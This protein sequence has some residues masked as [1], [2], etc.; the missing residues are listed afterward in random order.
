MNH[1]SGIDRYLKLYNFIEGDFILDINKIFFDVKGFEHPQDRVVAYPRYFP[2]K[3]SNSD[4]MYYNIKYKKVYNLEDRIDILKHELQSYYVYDRVFDDYMCEVPVKN[5][6]KHFKPAIATEE[7]CSNTNLSL[8]KKVALSLI[9]LISDV[10]GV[11]IKYI[12]ISGSIMIDLYRNDS[13][14]DLI[15][16]GESNSYKVIR[17]LNK[18]FNEGLLRKYEG[19]EISKLYKFRKAYE[20]TNLKTFY[21]HEKRKLYQGIYNNRE[22][23]IRFVKEPSHKYGDYTYKNLGRIEAIAVITDDKESI[24]TPSTYYAKI[25]DILDIKLKEESI[26]LDKTILICSYRGRFSQQVFEGETVK[27]H[28]KLESIHKNGRKIGNR[29]V[30]GGD[31]KDYMFSLD[32]ERL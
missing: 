12:G 10:S 28:G 22:F 25:Q 21:L 29:I 32:I 2:V 5:I 27:V 8:T 16:Y 18:L 3:N 26:N 13:D 15:V 31:K 30:I 24:F 14:I 11:N 17:G 7:L 19:R 4:R 9:R 6:I 20:Y 23:F 1:M